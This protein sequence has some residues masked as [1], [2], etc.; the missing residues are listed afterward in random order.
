MHVSDINECVHDN[1]G[2]NLDATCMNTDGSRTCVCDDGFQGNGFD[3]V[4]IDEC[5]MDIELC[6][7]GACVNFAGDYRCECNMG[8]SP[9]DNQHECI[10]Q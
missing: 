2:C 3:C 9:F 6:V 1:G 10:G 8:Y 5:A 4:D 7:N